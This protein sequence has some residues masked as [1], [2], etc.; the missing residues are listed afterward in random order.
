MTETMTIDDLAG[1]L[2]GPDVRVVDVRP[3]WAFNGWGEGTRT[4]HVR[5]AIA[6]PASWLQQIDDTRLRG[7]LLSKP[8]TPAHRIVA[9]GE[10]SDVDVFARRL[11]RLGYPSPL[12][13]EASFTELADDPRIPIEQLANYRQLVFPDWLHDLLETGDVLHPPAGPPVLLHANFGVPEE[14]LDGH[15]PGAL[16]LDTNVLESEETWNRRSPEELDQALRRLG[17]TTVT[18]VVVYG[19]D[20]AAD[21]A[22]QVPGRRIGQIAATRAAIILMYAGV[23]DVRVLD[24][25]YNAWVAA[26]YEVESEPN[27]PT[28]VAAFEADI[29]DRP[30]FIVDLDEARS[31]LRDPRGVLVSIRSW[32]EHVGRTSGYS[33]ID[34]TGDIPGAVWGNCGDSAYD[35]QYYRSLDNTM[36]PY[37]EIAADW[38]AAGI[39]PDKRVAFYCGTG[40]RASETWFYAYLMGWP[41]VALY[42]GGWFE[43]KN[44]LT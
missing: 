6:F 39:T 9:Y 12:R 40:W 16:Y 28:P 30:E 32:A 31:L 15:I 4:G 5:G 13:S 41:S 10:D 20:R 18:P 11:E 43:W 14:Y 27:E 26:G 21:P 17:I 42:D 3:T 19:R 1:F 34:E 2:D 37:T 36:K 29:P 24:G 22:E 35:M 38:R 44:H 23:R 7:L 8:L 25:G 33:Y